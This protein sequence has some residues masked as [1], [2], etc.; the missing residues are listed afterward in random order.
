MQ[1]KQLRTTIS[2][3]HGN[4]EG[5]GLLVLVL[6]LTSF[7]YLLWNARR[8][9]YQTNTALLLLQYLFQSLALSLEDQEINLPQAPMDLSHLEEYQLHKHQARMILRQQWLLFWSFHQALSFHRGRQ[10]GYSHGFLLLQRCGALPRQSPHQPQ[11]SDNHV[12]Q[13]QY[14]AESKKV[15][16]ACSTHRL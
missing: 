16:V 4:Q 12:H 9:F 11:Y 14:I 2:V 3:V 15:G 7:P 6:I 10:S 8:Q 5:H 13:Y 1:K